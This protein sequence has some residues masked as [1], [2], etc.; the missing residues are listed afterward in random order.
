MAKLTEGYT[1]SEIEQILVAAMYEA[2]YKNRGLR[3]SDVEKTINETVAISTTQREQIEALRMWARERAV[4]AT[5]V[6]DQEFEKG[7]TTEAG[8]GNGGNRQGGRIVNFDL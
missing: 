4:L 5:A 8:S 1:G 3:E 6:E 2:F 7:N